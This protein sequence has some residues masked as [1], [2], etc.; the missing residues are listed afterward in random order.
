MKINERKLKNGQIKLT[1]YGASAEVGRSAFVIEDDKRRVLIECGLKIM[2]GDEPTLAPD[3]IKERFHELDAVL[4]SHAHVDHSGYLPALWENGYFGKLYM[5]RPTLEIVQV[6]W[7]D[8]LKIEGNRHWSTSGMHRAISNTVTVDYHEEIEITEG[9]SIKYINAG[10]ILGSGMILI[11]WD[12]YKILFTGDINDKITPLFDG[13]EIP[14]G[15]ID[16]LITESTNGCR[17]VIERETINSEFIADVRRTLDLGNKVIIPC[18]A[19][20]RSQE[21]L[22]VL[23]EHIR[24]YPIYVDGMIKIMNQIT[25]KYLS[26]KWVSNSLITRMK[27]EGIYSPFRYENVIEISKD[28]FENTHDFRKYLC[29]SKDPVIILTT[30]GMMEPSPLHTHLRYAAKSNKNLITVVGYQ[31]EGTRGRDLLNGAKS[32]SLSI[33]WNREEMVSINAK[34]KRF[35]YSGHT[36]VQGI[37]NL[38]KKIN[39]KQ[40]Y[41]IHGDQK[42]QDDIREELSNGVIPKTLMPKKSEVLFD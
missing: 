18:F 40:I 37:K 23:T 21:L 24:D 14:E 5:T 27:N 32:I 36:S 15:E 42:E 17:E 1:G 41:M 6:L 19:L 33:D 9:V 34:I 2:P 20:G 25:E 26:E 35:H 11:D 22:T 30:S 31:A 29:K 4:L 16:V 12:G 10:H 8:H 38:A 28:N 39:A 7:L 13:F 3:G